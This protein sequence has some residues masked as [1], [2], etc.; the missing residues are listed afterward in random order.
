L[1]P[2]RKNSSRDPISKIT[3][4]KWTGSV[5][6]D[7]EHLSMKPKFKPQPHQNEHCSGPRN[8]FIGQIGAI[9]DVEPPVPH[10]CPLKPQEG[11]EPCPPFAAGNLHHF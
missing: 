7:I 2:A 1:R 4:T 10:W 5:A 6:E 8:C 3:K 11:H 9:C